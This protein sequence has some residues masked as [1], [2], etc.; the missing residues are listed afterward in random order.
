MPLVP[1]VI[2]SWPFWQG[3]VGSWHAEGGGRGNAASAPAARLTRVA[4]PC[5]CLSVPCA[6]CRQGARGQCPDGGAWLAHRCS[7]ASQRSGKGACPPPKPCSITHHHHTRVPLPWCQLSHAACGVRLAGVLRLH[8][9]GDERPGAPAAVV[10]SRLQPHHVRASG[11]HA[12]ARPAHRW[13][14]RGRQILLTARGVV[15]MVPGTSCRWQTPT[16]PCGTSSPRSRLRWCVAAASGSTCARAR[17]CGRGRAAVVGT[18]LP[19][20]DL[21]LA[22][23]TCAHLPLPLS[24]LCAA[25]SLPHS[26]APRSLNQWEPCR[27]L[28]VKPSPWLLMPPPL[29]TCRLC[30]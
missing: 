20:F 5:V 15:C 25:S 22:P 27:S 29:K 30:L 9:A 11:A 12:A 3:V 1:A 16:T 6:A 17:V 26:F 8:A 28:V 2:I 10:A 19:P 24:L 21:P 18:A 23:A 14:T 7:D 13:A 4:M